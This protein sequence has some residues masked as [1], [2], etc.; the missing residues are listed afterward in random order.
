MRNSFSGFFLLSFVPVSIGAEE[1]NSSSQAAMLTRGHSTRSQSLE[2]AFF[3][4]RTLQR[5]RYLRT[6]KGPFSCHL[7]CLIEISLFHVV[8]VIQNT[9][10]KT[11]WKLYELNKTTI[12]NKYKQHK[13]RNFWFRPLKVFSD[14]HPSEDAEMNRPHREINLDE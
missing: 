1:C 5:E 3:E 6:L 9:F 11:S 13:K 10:W 7:I 2:F 14:A 8:Y 4:Q 12:K